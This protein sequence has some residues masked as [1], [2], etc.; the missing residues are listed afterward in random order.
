MARCPE[1]FAEKEKAR[2][3]A[4]QASAPIPEPPWP[5]LEATY[6]CVT[7]SFRFSLLRFCKAK[8]NPC[9]LQKCI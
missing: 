4:R 1:A 3:G 7:T 9:I 2:A 6:S 8:N 5:G